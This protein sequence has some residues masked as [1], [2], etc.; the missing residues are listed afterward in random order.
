MITPTTP[1]PLLVCTSIHHHNT[2]A[3]ADA[4]AEVLHAEVVVPERCPYERL[5]DRPL[6]GIGS[7][8]YYG[9][10][11]PSVMQW[12]DGMPAGVGSPLRVFVFTTSGL[13]VLSPLWH[14]PVKQALSRKGTRLVGEFSCRGFDTWGPLW[15]AGGLNRHHPDARDLARARLFAEAMARHRLDPGETIGEHT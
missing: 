11:H 14:W 12:V 7:G 10:V 2:S 4:M 1:C 3:V 15:L 5:R 8:V 13:P 6:L 9:R